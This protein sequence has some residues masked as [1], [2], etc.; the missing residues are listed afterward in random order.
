MYVGRGPATAAVRREQAPALQSFYGMMK[1]F[2]SRK[3][4]RNGKT[5]NGTLAVPYWIL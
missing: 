4:E 3:W 5:G 2:H 1:N